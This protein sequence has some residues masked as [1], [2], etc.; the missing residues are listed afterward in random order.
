MAVVEF[1]K[2]RFTLFLL[3]WWFAEIWISALCWWFF[4][5]EEE[6]LLGRSLPRVHI[7]FN[8]IGGIVYIFIS[9]VFMFWPYRYGHCMLAKRRRQRISI[10]VLFVYFFR[11]SPCW[12]IEL[13]VLW[14]HGFVS[15]IQGIS[16]M[17]TAITWSIGT[18][19]VW[20]R[21]MWTMA[22]YFQSIYGDEDAGIE[23]YATPALQQGI[24][25]NTTR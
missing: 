6:P 19:I 9:S 24:G 22:K 15:E 10:G 14:T 3:F 8:I 7:A 16:F 1:R 11:D 20:Y 17:L 13:Y 25:A 21:Y 18:L 12:F 2:P 5:S 4:L 23:R